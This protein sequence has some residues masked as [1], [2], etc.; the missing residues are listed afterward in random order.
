MELD[1]YLWR[2]RDHLSLKQLWDYY[3]RYLY[4]SRLKDQEVLLGAIKEGVGTLDSDTF[5]YAQ[6]FDEAT[7][8]YLGLAANQVVSPMLD[9]SSVVVKP[10]AAQRQRDADEAAERARQAQRTTPALDYGPLTDPVPP[11]NGVKDGGTTFA[12]PT[13]PPIVKPTPKPRRYHGR[14]ETGSQRLGVFAGTIANEIVQHL[15]LVPGAQVTIT[16]EIQA[17]VPDGVPENV[18]RTVAENSRTLHF[19]SSSFEE[20]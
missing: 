12:D 6:G 10:A 20:D 3:C 9:G 13:A 16:I 1:K 7:G 11:T 2:D 8:R 5:A 19:S 4:L 15:A 17:T 18:V 14:V